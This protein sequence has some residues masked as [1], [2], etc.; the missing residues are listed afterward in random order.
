[1][2]LITAKNSVL[3]G[4]DVVVDLGLYFEVVENGYVQPLPIFLNAEFYAAEIEVDDIL[5]YPWL[6]GNQMGVFPHLE[7]L[8]LDQPNFA[9]LYGWKKGRR[10]RMDRKRRRKKNRERAIWPILAIP[11]GGSISP[12]KFGHEPGRWVAC[13]YAV[14]EPEMKKIIAYFGVV[15]QRDC[16]SN[17]ENSIFKRFGVRGARTGRMPLCKVGGRGFCG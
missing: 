1:M 10:K 9:L 15:P 2:R 13:D 3:K 17:T 8:A 12:S 6:K 11:G 16:F 7:A 5:S 14:R 4:G